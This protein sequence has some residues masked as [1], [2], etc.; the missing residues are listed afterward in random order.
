MHKDGH[1]E[2]PEQQELR[3]KRETQDVLSEELRWL[4]I[5]RPRRPGGQQPA[6]LAALCLSGG[7]IRSAS[8]C[9]GALQALAQ[10]KILDKFHYLS[11]VSG[12]GYIG[13]WLSAWMAREGQASVIAQLGNAQAGEEP[14]P[15]R[16]LRSYTNYLSPVWGFS[17]DFLVL[18]ATFVRNLAINWVVL[19]PLI[20]A[21][22]LVPR[23]EVALVHVPGKNVPPS[24]YF[25]LL[26]L[27]A[28]LVVVPIAYVVADVP[29]AQAPRPPRS[30]FVTFCFLPL[31]AAAVI[32]GW[33][34]AWTP[35][36]ITQVADGVTGAGTSIWWLAGAGALI[37]LAAMTLGRA[38]RVERGLDRL[39]LRGGDFLV[40]IGSGIAGGL[41]LYFVAWATGERQLAR[42]AELF[43]T[44]NVPVLLIVFWAACTV[45]TAGT[46][47][48]KEEDEREWWARSSA[49]WLGAGLAWLAGFVLVVYVPRWVLAGLGLFDHDLAAP[50]VAGTGAALVGVLTSA[51]GYWSKNGAKIRKEAQT[52][53]QATGANA[54]KLL[55]LVSV[56]ALAVGLS[57]GVSCT[58]RTAY[59]GLDRDVRAAQP[60][61]ATLAVR[62][63]VAYET[64]LEN[65]TPL[66]IFAGIVLLSL[67]GAGASLAAGVNTFSLHNLYGNRLARAYL[68]A[69]NLDRHPHWFTGFDPKDNP[70]LAQV[71]QRKPGDEP[72][73][74][75]HVINVA[76]NIVKPAGGR[77]EW[78]QRM[79]ASFT[80]T[81]LHCGSPVLGFVPTAKYGAP[82]GGTSLGRAMA[83]SGAA[84]SPNMG[85]HTAKLVA[86]VMTFFNVRLG[87]W[88]PNTLDTKRKLWD[89]R[90]PRLGIKPLLD[91]AL[92]TTAINRGFVYLSDG[93]H[94]ENL[95]LYEMVRRGCTRILVIDASCDPRDEFECLEGAIR[96]VRVDFG[97]AIEFEE[98]LPT[99]RNAHARKRSIAVGRIRY[100]DQRVG[101]LVYL[102]PVLVGDEP[103]DVTRFAA[104][105][106]RKGKAFPHQPTSDQ[107]FNES[108]FESYRMLGRHSVLRHFTQWQPEWA[109]WPT[110]VP[111]HEE[112]DLSIHTVPAGPQREGLLALLRLAREATD[113]RRSDAP[114]V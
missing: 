9:L 93:G 75:F 20:A 42:G 104:A 103:L 97:V 28:V 102:K 46:S 16:R 95:G 40:S 12:G 62:A 17:T 53:L 59:A 25:P 21:V 11:T 71:G 72:H 6:E 44:L 69:S 30:R 83:I 98:P 7:G 18:V 35:S 92:A 26:L 1:D 65:S 29:P 34:I 3:L 112:T 100:P 36:R 88:S 32:L 5:E 99:A 67:L 47:R 105:N 8:F 55:S 94:F 31:I 58:L 79:A 73:R 76:L 114:R 85:Y 107:F 70:L 50:I 68:G 89:R 51:I 37:Q 74:L 106:D 82:H 64:V 84:A 52:L 27:A 54:M 24:V 63:N 45:F 38:W 91:E 111:A 22:L 80:M 87:W 60:A 108:Q 39:P 81:P 48:I 110:A 41:L 109:S 101:E 113:P 66:E 15:L 19:V 13:S 2:T 61:T 57:I 78:Q 90:E 56:L 43:A 10:L 33:L 96:K 77:L 49:W 14:K 4:G 86:F 23:L